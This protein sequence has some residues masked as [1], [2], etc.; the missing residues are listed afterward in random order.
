MTLTAVGAV[1]ALAAPLVRSISVVSSG[2]DDCPGG[3]HAMTADSFDLVSGDPALALLA[4]GR[5]ARLLPVLSRNGVFAVSVLSDGQRPL[6]TWFASRRRGEGAAQFESVGWRPAA[7]VRAALIDGGLAWYECS[8]EQLV[9]AGDH[10]LVVGRVLLQD[11]SV[12]PA[13]PLLRFGGSY[14]E[15]TP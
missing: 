13:A 11:T 3:M 1:P 9:P 2:L 6:A 12:S 14:R 4:I 15:L 8:V 5:Q 7:V 10:V